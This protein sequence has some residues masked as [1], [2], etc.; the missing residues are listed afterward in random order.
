ME[1]VAQKVR[2]M[3]RKALPVQA[4][5]IQFREVQTPVRNTLNTFGRI[6]IL[7]NNI[8]GGHNHAGLGGGVIS[9]R[10]FSIVDLTDDD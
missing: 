2:V 7:V 6:D 1:E 10:W 9:K 3:G 4:D 8:G 5:V